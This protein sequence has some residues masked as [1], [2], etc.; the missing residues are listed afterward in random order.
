MKRG[1]ASVD[2]IVRELQDR[3]NEFDGIVFDSLVYY[4]NSTGQILSFAQPKC[5]ANLEL[6]WFHAVV[7]DHLP[8]SN[9]SVL[10]YL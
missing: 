7:V 9:Q 3:L 5:P 6:R 4:S 1:V 10:Y 2:D 8:L